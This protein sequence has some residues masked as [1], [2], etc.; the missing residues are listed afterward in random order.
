MPQDCSA[1]EY[2]SW[3]VT[4]LQ[5][6]GEGSAEGDFGLDF[7]VSLFISASRLA[8]GKLSVFVLTFLL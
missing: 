4:I 8:L 7:T 2:G 3:S 1:I 5:G 6:S